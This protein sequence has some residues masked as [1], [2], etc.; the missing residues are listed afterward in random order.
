LKEK[1]AAPVYKSENT[2]VGIRT[3]VSSAERLNCFQTVPEP[4]GLLLKSLWACSGCLF[5]TFPAYQTHPEHLCCTCNP[6]TRCGANKATQRNHRLEERGHTLA[7]GEFFCRKNGCGSNPEASVQPEQRSVAF[8][9]F[10]SRA[11]CTRNITS[12]LCPT[13]VAL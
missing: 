13:K 3:V 6:T 11:R 9:L 7:R 2:A 8:Y 1:V 12:T 10:C 4:H 5:Y